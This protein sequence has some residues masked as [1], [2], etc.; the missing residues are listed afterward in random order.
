MVLLR[1]NSELKDIKKILEILNNILPNAVFQVINPKY[2]VSSKQIEIALEKAKTARK[3]GINKSNSLNNELLLW[4]CAEKHV[5]EAIKKAG[6]KQ[7]NDFFLFYEGKTKVDTILKE[8][9]AKKKK[10][11]FT[12]D[13]KAFKI[14]E[15]L[16]KQYSL[17]DLVLEKMA[18]SQLDR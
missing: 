15:K 11:I 12:P 17:E 13:L 3:L 16:L 4:I 6:A 18:I 7:T 14:D 9:K 10:L 2:V 1:I 8:I 5:S